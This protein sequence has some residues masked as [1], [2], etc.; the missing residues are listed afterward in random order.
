MSWRFWK[1]PGLL[2]QR[3]KT[4]LWFEIIVFGQYISKIAKNCFPL[5]IILI[6]K[7]KTWVS[8][9]DGPRRNKYPSKHKSDFE[10]PKPL[11]TWRRFWK[12]A[13]PSD[14]QKRSPPT[15]TF[16]ILLT[17]IF[18]ASPSKRRKEF[19]HNVF[20]ITWI[21]YK[22]FCVQLKIPSYIR[23]TKPAKLCV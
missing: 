23:T 9:S 21:F 6:N 4:T 16:T 12:H 7:K 2:R 14:S 8:S 13:R 18:V 20:D 5:V 17:H 22:D 19:L 10:Y 3:L 11:K 15:T 1:Y